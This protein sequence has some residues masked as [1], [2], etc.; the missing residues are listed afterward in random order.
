MAIA[1]IAANDSFR[2]APGVTLTGNLGINNGA[3]LDRDPDGT[4]LGWV[5]GLYDPASAGQGTN[6]GLGFVDG[7][8]NFVTVIQSGY[9]TRPVWT[10]TTTLTTPA[11]GQV[12]VQTDGTFSYTPRAGFAGTDRFTYTLVDGEM[13]SATAVA[14]IA[15][16]AVAAAPQGTTLADRLTGTAGNDVIRALDGNDVVRGAGGRDTVYGGTGN[17]AVLGDAG[18]DL[19]MGESGNDRLDGGLD[20]DRLLGG[21]GTDSLIGGAGND[22]LDG[23]VALDRLTGGA[24]ADTFVM[25]TTGVANEDI[26]ADWG[27]G[28][29]VGVSGRAL[30]L[31]AG[32]PL[33]DDYLVTQGTAA[34]GHARLVES[35]DGLRLYLDADGDGATADRLLASFAAP[36]DLTEA[37]V[38]LL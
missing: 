11:G 32:T 2:V 19:L 12:A 27:T 3:G 28:D 25:V 5:A 10:T 15:V 24:G 34:S 36:V 26:I 31:R 14:T 23:G 13:K 35:R 7:M 29:R 17:D 16:G 33:A 21:S 38:L 6:P 18:T 30:G 37:S 4:L 22:V 9:V 8:L 20:A 1:P